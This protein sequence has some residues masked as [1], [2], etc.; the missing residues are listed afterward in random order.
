MNVWSSGE[1]S[2]LGVAGNLKLGLIQD[3]DSISFSLGIGVSYQPGVL[4]WESQ[5]LYG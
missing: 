4:G 2:F 1:P 3:P 5:G